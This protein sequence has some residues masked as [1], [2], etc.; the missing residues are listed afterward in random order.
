MYATTLVQC[1]YVCVCVLLVDRLFKK[2]DS[3][4]SPFPMATMLASTLG[5]I[6]PSQQILQ[7]FVGLN[8]V[9]RRAS[10]FAVQ[11][12]SGSTWISLPPNFR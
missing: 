12:M 10:A 5:S 2:R 3:S 9:G 7:A 8:M 4:L 11:I 6:V 1:V